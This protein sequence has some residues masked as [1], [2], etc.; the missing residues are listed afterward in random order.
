MDKDVT[1]NVTIEYDELTNDYY[2]VLPD[3]LLRRLGWKEN[4]T[5][6]WTDNKDGTYTLK[7]EESNE[8]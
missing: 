1:T 2:A 6:R 8:Q 4:D 5:L 3:E 7:K